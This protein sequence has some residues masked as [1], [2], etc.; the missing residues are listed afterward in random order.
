MRVFTKRMHAYTHDAHRACMRTVAVILA[1]SYQVA[2]ATASVAM[3]TVPATL[4][5]AIG[6]PLET[7][8]AE[9][10]D[11]RQL[12]Q[13]IRNTEGVEKVNKLTVQKNFDVVL[14]LCKEFRF[15]MPPVGALVEALMTDTDVVPK[16]HSPV[17]QRAWAKY[18]CTKLRMLVAH[19]A[20]LCQR[21][22]SSK[23]TKIN[24]LMTLWKEIFKD[25][26]TEEMPEDQHDHH[27]GIEHEDDIEIISSDSGGEEDLEC[28]YPSLVSKY[29][30]VPPPDVRLQGERSKNLSRKA[31]Q[32]ILRGEDPPSK[33][34]KTKKTKK[35]KTTAAKK[36]AAKKAAAKKSA[37]KKAP[38]AK[39]KKTS[40]GEIATP[41]KAHRR[42]AQPLFQTP[43]KTE[44]K[45]STKEK[46]ERGKN[47][48]FQ[49]KCGKLTG[50]QVSITEGTDFDTARALSMFMC[51]LLNSGWSV[52][53]TKAAKLALLNLEGV[54]AFGQHFT[55]KKVLA[56]AP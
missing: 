22:G 51:A 20:R 14:P 24:M 34:K 4:K 12:S 6:K 17:A 8:A 18:E 21:S 32:A 39:A 30:D 41:K 43:E 31:R 56:E 10:A 49:L 36:A 5:R 55:L 23:C 7:I 44:M 54:D 46:L 13:L 26:S 16:F 9:D 28:P 50:G 40:A 1:Q 53:Q 27:P 52:E 15:R 38:E 11:S 25:H 2:M 48:F 33:K 47:H 29:A 37:A 35:K 42:D 45:W 19:C 3:S